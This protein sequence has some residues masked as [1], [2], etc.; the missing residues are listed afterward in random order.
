MSPKQA[1]IE[2]EARKRAAIAAS[3]KVTFRWVRDELTEA[4][5]QRCDEAFAALCRRTLNRMRGIAQ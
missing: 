3:I 4:E 2:R 1:A 5:R